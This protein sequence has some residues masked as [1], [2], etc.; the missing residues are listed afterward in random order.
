[1]EFGEEE[2]KC[3]NVPY[4]FVI[5]FMLCSLKRTMISSRGRLMFI[6]SSVTHMNQ[7]ESRGS[8]LCLIWERWVSIDG[9]N[10]DETCG[11]STVRNPTSR[12][13]SA[14]EVV[15]WG[16]QGQRYKRRGKKKKEEKREKR[17]KPKENSFFLKR[18]LHWVWFKKPL[19]PE[20]GSK[21]KQG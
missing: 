6:W 10:C 11:T 5:Y 8:L 15:S 4:L 17:K 20:Q 18:G 1:M 9:K 21:K 16:D 13:S 19:N 12:E 2:N 3:N 14:G 7:R